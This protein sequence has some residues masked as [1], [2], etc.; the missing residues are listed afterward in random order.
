MRTRLLLPALLALAAVNACGLFS[1]DAEPRVPP[2]SPAPPLPEPALVV[3]G[4]VFAYAVNG[5]PLEGFSEPDLSVQTLLVGNTEVHVRCPRR[6]TLSD[7]G[8]VW[9]ENQ[10]YAASRI[11]I[12]LEK[13]YRS[14]FREYWY[15]RDAGNPMMAMSP[16][17]T[18]DSPRG[19]LLYA[20]C[21]R[22]DGRCGI[23]YAL[24]TDQSRA[25]SGIIV[26]GIWPKGNDR[27]LKPL[28]PAIA[29]NVRLSRK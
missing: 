29:N 7:A 3:R 27:A 18:F 4:Q 5:V 15:D 2:A 16:L 22:E 12:H 13:Y 6:W 24:L 14:A 1:N 21:N 23:V 11:V 10:D 26:H 19:P 20:Y 25:D 28:V 8:A 9:M 17:Q